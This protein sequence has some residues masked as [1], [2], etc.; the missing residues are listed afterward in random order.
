MANSGPNTNGSQF[1]LVADES[2]LPN[3]Y[4]IFGTISEDG[5]ETLDG[6]IEENADANQENG[7]DGEPTDEVK[8]ETA[9][10]DT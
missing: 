5:L 2:Q 9:S 3:D 4:T 8:I 6:I 10:V 1:F 7:G